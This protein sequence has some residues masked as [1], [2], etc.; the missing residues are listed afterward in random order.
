MVA[1]FL[2]FFAVIV[3]FSAA[4]EMM[5]ADET[6]KV[7]SEY[8]KMHH[9]HVELLESQCSSTLVKHIKSPLHLVSL[10][11]FLLDFSLSLSG[12]DQI[13]KLP[14]VSN[15]IELNVNGLVVCFLVKKVWSLVR[16]FDQ[17]QKYKPFISGCVVK[18]KKLEIG[19][20]REVDV[21]SGLPATKS[22][23][24][25]EFLDDN[26]HVLSIRIVGGDHRLKVKS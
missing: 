6:K 18:D 4:L 23:E 26:Q 12:Y 3:T 8:I 15:T 20:V 21:R 1:H 11:C 7:E 2:L 5:N 19:S 16:R 10:F 25:L 14:S 17:P 9:V 13:R 22:T 24:I